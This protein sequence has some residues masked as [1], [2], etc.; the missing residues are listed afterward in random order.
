MSRSTLLGVWPYRRVEDW[1]EFSNSWGTAM[2]VWQMM[3]REYFGHD[4]PLMDE[5]EAQ[6]VWDLWKRLD[7]PVHHRA[8][9]LMTFDYAYI[10]SEDYEQAASD[11]RKFVSDF[12]TQETSN[13]WPAIADALEIADYPA[14]GLWATS[15]SE[16]PFTGL[17][18]ECIDDYDP[19]DWT[20]ALDVYAAL[21]E[22][23]T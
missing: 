21:L 15:V 3:S 18:N 8:V 9:L 16:R 2:F 1:L 20:K 19:F 7:I 12:S 6:K 11:I 5:L 23:G 10:R 22:M 4:F 17:W 13:H 14:I